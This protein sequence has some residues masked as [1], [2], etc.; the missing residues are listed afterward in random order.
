MPLRPVS[1]IE[2]AW[3]AADAVHP[4]FVNQMVF[5]GVGHFEVEQWRRAAEAASRANPGACAVLRGVGCQMRWEQGPGCSVRVVDGRSWDG[6]SGDGAPFLDQA[7][8]LV[9]GPTTELLLVQGDPLRVVL[10][11]PHATMDGGGVIAFA[12]DLFRALRG[13]ELVGHP[14]SVVDRDLAGPGEAS[15][16][17]ESDALPPMG[18]ADGGAHGVEW[19][20]LRVKGP[21]R[22]ILGRVACAIAAQ[23]RRAGQGTVRLEVPVDLRRAHPHVRSTANLTGLL[24]VEIA[25]DASPDEVSRRIRE[26]VQAGRPAERIRGAGSLRHVPQWLINAGARRMA[27]THAGRT[28]FK[29]TAIVSNVGRI[30]LAA[31]EAPGFATSAVFFIP[32]GTEVTPLFVTL[33]GT[34]SQLELALASPRHF[35]SGGRLDALVDAVRSALV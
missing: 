2:R 35:A 27:A 4:P 10:R 28:H 11:T 12:N 31:F 20:R 13:E 3:I 23:A 6:Q 5:E 26:A 17:L 8:S 25:E 1:G 30:D 15:A 19:R 14:D 33:A 29:T 16:E 34:R 7:L 18:T 24:A 32:P 21:Q 9:H 22:P